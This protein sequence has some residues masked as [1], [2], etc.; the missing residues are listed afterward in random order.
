MIVLSHSARSA[1]IETPGS[2]PPPLF[3]GSHSAR[4]AWIET[5][6]TVEEMPLPRAASH[7]A[8]SAWIETYTNIKKRRFQT[9]ALR[10][11]C[12]D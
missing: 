11:E 5:Y 6:R 1:W 12:V 2:R 7:S 10:K 3:S 8:R 9:V 4:S